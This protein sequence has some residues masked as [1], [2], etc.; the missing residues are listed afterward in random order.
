MHGVEAEQ[1][2]VGR[3]RAEIVDA[4]HLDIRAAGLGDGAQ[5]VAA[6]AAKSVDRDANCHG[7]FLLLKADATP[8]AL[9]RG[10]LTAE[11]PVRPDGNGQDGTY[12]VLFP[13]NL[14]RISPSVLVPTF[15]GSHPR[16][17][18]TFA[19]LGKLM[20]T[21]KLMILGPLFELKCLGEFSAG[22]VGTSI[23]RP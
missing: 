8:R 20:G 1:M 11:R 5:H 2:G 22:S 6:D 18:T 21:S 3:D 14:N 16:R 9:P 12:L 17:R 4:D 13:G 15:R 7:S 23:R 19:N 10:V